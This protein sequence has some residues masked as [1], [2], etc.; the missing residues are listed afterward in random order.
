[1]A[2]RQRL[3][4]LMKRVVAQQG[5]RQRQLQQSR[6]QPATPARMVMAKPPPGAVQR[7]PAGEIS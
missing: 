1:M 2:H 4:Q 7:Q 6:A 3:E 5:A